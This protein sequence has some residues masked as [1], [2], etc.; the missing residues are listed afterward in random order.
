MI[1]RMCVYCGS[2]RADMSKYIDSVIELAGI[3][4]ERNIELVYGGASVGLMGALADSVLL[5]GGRVIGV[6]PNEIVKKYEVAHRDLTELHTVDSMHER[7]M[8]M[9]ELSDAFIALPGGLGTFEEIIEVMTWNQLGFIKKPAG[10]LNIKGFYNKLREFFE[11]VI[12]EKF[13]YHEY[14]HRIIFED[15]PLILYEKL[16]DDNELITA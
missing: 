1:K 13:I 6:I 8:K 4:V 3:L 15:D 16:I 9:A 2:S 11:H 5:K 10:F 7:K 12:Q 14:M